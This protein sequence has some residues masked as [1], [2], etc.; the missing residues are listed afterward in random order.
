MMKFRNI[1]LAGS[2]LALSACGAST[3]DRALTGGAIGAAAGA[4]GA[5]ITGGSVVGGT[6]IGG[7]AG[8]VAGAVTDQSQVDLGDPIYQ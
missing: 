1:A 7:A 4:A 6:V 5:A 3:G 2:L 8:A